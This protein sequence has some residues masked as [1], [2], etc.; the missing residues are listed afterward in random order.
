MEFQ[1]LCDQAVLSTLVGEAS[2]QTLLQTT[3]GRIAPLVCESI[4]KYRLNSRVIARL[5][6]ARELV[7]RGLAEEL[8][9][10][11]VLSSPDRVRDY[12]RLFFAGLEHEVFCTLFLDAQN[13]LLAAEELFRGTLTQTSVYPREV[14]KRVLFHNSCKVVF[15]HNHPSGKAEPSRADESITDLLVRALALIDVHV[16]DHFIVGGNSIKSFAEAGLL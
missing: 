3:G 5:V 13:R 1:N 9:T 16:L 2:A 10:F 15:A 12:L 4:A 11:S 6:A 8:Q 14:V 7:R